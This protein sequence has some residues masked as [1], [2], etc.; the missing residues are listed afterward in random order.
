MGGCTFALVAYI[1]HILAEKK[2]SSPGTA[3]EQVGAGNDSTLDMQI[4]SVLPFAPSQIEQDLER[5][6]SAD[7]ERAAEIIR[8]MQLDD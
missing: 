5:L 3:Q 7:P 1:D 2:I 6:L 4:P 8:K